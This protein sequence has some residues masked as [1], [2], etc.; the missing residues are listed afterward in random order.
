M[1]KISIPPI[2]FAN[3]HTLLSQFFVFVRSTS[4]LKSHSVCSSL[5][6]GSKALISVSSAIGIKLMPKAFFIFADQNLK[7]FLQIIFIKSIE[8]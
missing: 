6:L 3:A 4:R 7:L 1:P 5:S 8:I 2:P